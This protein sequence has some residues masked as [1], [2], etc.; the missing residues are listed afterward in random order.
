MHNLGIYGW[1]LR[2]AL[3]KSA[4]SCRALIKRPRDNPI[5]Q[6]VENNT[7]RAA[8]RVYPSWP[9]SSAQ[10]SL[11]EDAAALGADHDE[12]EE[13]GIET[14]L[15]ELGANN[16]LGSVVRLEL[17][18]ES[19]RVSRPRQ[20]GCLHRVDADAFCFRTIGR[21]RA[22]PTDQGPPCDAGGAFMLSAL[23]PIDRFD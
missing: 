9:K 15:V 10:M 7:E 3:S 6:M 19:R 18:L 8:L 21:C 12:G 11:L 20:E 4:A 5:D 14:L 22:G 2:D 16:A 1:D 23:H 17:C 13:A